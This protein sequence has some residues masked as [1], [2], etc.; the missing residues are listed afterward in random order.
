MLRYPELAFL[1]MDI[2]E[3][4]D[5]LRD[6]KFALEY[7]FENR[8]RMMSVF[9]ET[10]FEAVPE[11]NFI[12]EINI[13]HNYASLEYHLGKNL[14]IHRKGATSTKDGEIGIIPGSMGTASYIVKGLGNEESFTS[15]SHG[16]GRTMSRIA[17][18]MNLSVEECDAAMEG[19]VYERWGK[20][21]GFDKRHKG[22]LDLS[23]AP[24]A[25]KPID[26]VIDAEADL[27]QP[28]VRLTPLAVLKG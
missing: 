16:A 3:G 27:V 20:Y 12:Q 21:K 14:Y 17:A 23:E 6:M 11:T 1:P 10:L 25:Y 28:L 9:K 15:C 4:H 13:H 18:S 2:Q 19:I 7:A 22:Y 8:Q 26:D 5:Y 24:Q